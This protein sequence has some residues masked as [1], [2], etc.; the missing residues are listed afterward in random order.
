MSLR[1]KVA[2]R[3]VYNSV[4]MVPRPGFPSATTVGAGHEV[5]PNSLHSAWTASR[6][7][8]SNK[9]FAHARYVA[10]WPFLSIHLSTSPIL[11]EKRDIERNHWLLLTSAAEEKTCYHA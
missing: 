5:A 7:S 8:A 1:L 9:H 11:P 3:R 4:H 10:I 2:S 6:L